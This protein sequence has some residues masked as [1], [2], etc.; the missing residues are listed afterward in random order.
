M[1]RVDPITGNQVP[2]NGGAKLTGT[3]GHLEIGIMDVDTRSSG[4]NPYANFAVVRL[5]ESLWAGSYV[6]VMGIDKRSGNVLD[7]FN[8]TGGVDTRLVFFKDWFVDAHMAG[9]QSP[10][11]LSGNSDVG[12]SLS[13]RSN[14]LDDVVE[15]RRSGPNS[16]PE[17]GFIQ[18]PG[19]KRNLRRP[20]LQSEASDKRCP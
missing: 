1:K 6:G 13:Y 20:H 7:D 16:N 17:V 10:G 8:Q 14:W 4:P 3:I 15:R 5:K 19:F 2:I 9:T 11:N 12:A 18:R